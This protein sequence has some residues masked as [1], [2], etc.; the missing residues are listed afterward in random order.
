M[1]AARLPGS[2]NFVNFWRTS[3][4]ASAV[5]PAAAAFQSDRFVSR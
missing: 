2:G 4:I 5:K 3:T 1:T